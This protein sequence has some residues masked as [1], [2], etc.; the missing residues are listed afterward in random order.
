KVLDPVATDGLSDARDAAALKQRVQGLMQTELAAVRATAKRPGFPR[1]HG[2]VSRL[3]MAGVACVLALLVGVSVF[4]NNWC[5]AEPPVYDGSRA[6]AEEEVIERSVDGNPLHLLGNNWRR[7]RDG[8]HEVALS[9]NPWERG[10]ANARL[11]RDL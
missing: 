10:Y 11:N 3:G 8:I 6:L 4:V 9:G 5:I 7:K 2:W 1:I